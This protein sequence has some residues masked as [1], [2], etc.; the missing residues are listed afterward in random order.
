MRGAFSSCG[1][2]PGLAG[3]LLV[4]DRLCGSSGAAQQVLR[5]QWGG[6]E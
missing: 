3:Q 1:S 4:Q 5:R 2:W 6:L